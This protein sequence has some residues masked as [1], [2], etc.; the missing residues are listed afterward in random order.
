MLFNAAA[1]LAWAGLLA[2]AGYTFGRA[3]LDA[4][5]AIA[6]I[7]PFVGVAIVLTV[8]LLLRR[9]EGRLQRR[10]DASGQRSTMTGT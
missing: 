9:I 3:A 6:A 8:L 2:A 7:A 5:G 1:C 10:A 4:G